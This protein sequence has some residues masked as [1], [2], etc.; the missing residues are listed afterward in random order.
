MK[1]PTKT[2]KN[3]NSSRALKTKQQSS[4]GSFLSGYRSSPFS[5]SLS[6]DA[7][8]VTDD[9]WGDKRD[10]DHRRGGGNNNN[11]NTPHL[12]DSFSSREREP[13]HTVASGVPN[14]SVVVMVNNLP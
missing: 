11:N 4:D 7:E 12:R 14:S 1:T 9:R 8:G 6:A 2:K 5:L 3:N 10:R 13:Q